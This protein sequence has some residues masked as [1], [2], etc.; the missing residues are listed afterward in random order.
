MAQQAL[1]G[2]PA[3]NCLQMPI[4]ASADVDQTSNLVLTERLMP[5]G[6]FGPVTLRTKRGTVTFLA[7]L[8]TIPLTCASVWSLLS[9]GPRDQ[10]SEGSQPS[11]PTSGPQRALSSP[12]PSL[13]PEGTKGAAVRERLWRG[14][15]Q[16]LQGQRWLQHWQEHGQHCAPRGG[17]AAVAGQTS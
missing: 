2:A 10:P 4:Y 5:L 3:T 6:I 12:F 14:L 13:C 17:G 7:G 11:S 16:A 1:W 9:A 8:V 15:G